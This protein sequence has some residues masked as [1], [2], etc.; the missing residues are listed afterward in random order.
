MS[1]LIW[2]QTVD[3]LDGIPERKFRKKIILK[4]SADGKT[5]EKLSTMQS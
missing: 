5:H 2:I 1:D 3:T 4:K